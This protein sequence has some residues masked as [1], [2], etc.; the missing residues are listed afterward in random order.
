MAPESLYQGVYTTKSDVWVNDSLSLD[1]EN[2]PDWKVSVYC[3]TVITNVVPV[4]IESF[5]LE[6]EYDYEYEIF[7]ILSSEA[8]S[9]WQE[10]VIVVVILLRVLA[11][12]EIIL[13]IHS[14]PKLPLFVYNNAGVKSPP[15]KSIIFFAQIWNQRIERITV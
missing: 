13:F 11:N 15:I 10:N 3:T 1:K 7:S 14:Y 8:A 2:T 12:A 9:F 4:K 5:R 6:D